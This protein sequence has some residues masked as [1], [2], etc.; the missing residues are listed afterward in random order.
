MKCEIDE[1]PFVSISYHITFDNI[2]SNP[3]AEKQFGR[4]DADGE[5]TLTLLISSMTS[6]KWENISCDTQR[7]HELDTIYVKLI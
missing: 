1:I 6:S 4:A 2:D 5:K 7:N 3:L